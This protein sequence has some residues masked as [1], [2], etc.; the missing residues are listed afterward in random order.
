MMT[1]ATVVFHHWNDR[2]DSEKGKQS[3]TMKKGL[4]AGKNPRRERIHKGTYSSHNNKKKKSLKINIL[5][6]TVEWNKRERAIDTYGTPHTHVFV[7]VAEE[8]VSFLFQISTPQSQLLLDTIQK[9]SKSRPKGKDER[10]EE[11]KE[12]QTEK[13]I[14]KKKKRQ[15]ITIKK[16]G[17]GKR[18]KYV[19]FLLLSW[20]KKEKKGPPNP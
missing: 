10:E 16:G 6:P 4:K 2:Y 15:G 9:V 20:V 12:A 1:A 13:Y 18:E 11:E 5:L 7:C 19:F 3:R 8:E 14:R 17:S